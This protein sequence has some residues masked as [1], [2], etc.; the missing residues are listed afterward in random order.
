MMQKTLQKLLRAE[1]VAGIMGVSLRVAKDLMQEMPR[2]NIG[3]STD[4]P[5][6]AVEETTL[7]A[8]L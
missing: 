8:F 2:V 4:H 6:W 5:R 7:H 1:D 3:R